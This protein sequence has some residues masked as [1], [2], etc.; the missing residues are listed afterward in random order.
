MNP[1]LLLGAT[2]A[3]EVAATSLLNASNGFARPL[4]GLAAV[5][6]YALCFWILAFVFQ[7]IPMAVA[8]AVWSGVGIAA[9]ALIGTFAF[10][11]TLAPVQLL[12]IALIAIGA[13]GLNLTT[14]HTP[15]PR[16]GTRPSAG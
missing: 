1:W 9:I 8:Y 5:T 16:I 4:Y 14:P 7:R 13:V 6:L 3:L 15:D 10:R 2:I 12:F 11:Q